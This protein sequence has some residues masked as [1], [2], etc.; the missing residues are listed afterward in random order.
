MP[1]S[2]AQLKS[3]DTTD[4]V[5]VHRVFR[6]EF[7]LLPHLVRSVVPFDIR[8]ARLVAAHAEEMIGAL[9][10]HHT[11]ED[12]LLWPKL[13]ERA[14]LEGG[15]LER[16]QLQHEQLADLL[17]RVGSLRPEWERTAAADARAELAGL[18]GE[19]SAE[20]DAHLA[21]EEREILPEVQRCISAS[22]W[23][24]LGERGLAAIPKQRLLVFLGHILEEATP[25]ERI[26]FL[27]RVPVPARVLF[28]MVGERRYRREVS[29]LR[30]PLART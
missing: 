1:G 23:A 27:R 4:M 5:V 14:D 13:A 20:L 24:E 22:E 6:R 26:Q 10:H 17:D 16:M 28:R 30:A 18:L 2:S 3:C 25:A 21:A 29:T 7:R 11:G 9:H 19:F 12:E 8:R 15:V